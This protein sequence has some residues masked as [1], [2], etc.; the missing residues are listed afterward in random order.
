MRLIRLYRFRPRSQPP[1]KMHHMYHWFKSE[2]SHA[3]IEP[4]DTFEISDEGPIHGSNENKP[5][6]VKLFRGILRL[7]TAFENFKK[8]R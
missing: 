2:I 1:F 3:S 8:R 5:F 6:A 4:V 7:K